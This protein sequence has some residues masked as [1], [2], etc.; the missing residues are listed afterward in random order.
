M[1]IK[2]VSN[3]S[4]R[5]DRDRE[6]Y[7]SNDMNIEHELKMRIVI[8]I[9][10]ETKKEIVIGKEKKNQNRRPFHWETQRPT[11]RVDRSIISFLFLM[12]Y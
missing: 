8:K 1:K 7:R 2:I 4:K 12:G 11:S 5:K 10:K 6:I 3:F 9:I